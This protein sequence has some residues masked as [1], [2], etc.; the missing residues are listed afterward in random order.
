VTSGAA[1][2]RYAR[3]LFDVVLRENG[4]LE[5]VQR[6]F[7]QFVDL[8]AQHPVLATTLGNPAIPASKKK[9]V[10]QALVDR[11]GSISPVVAKLIMLLAERDRVMLLPDIARIFRE[12]LM[13]H[14]KVIR[15]EVTTAVA[16]PSEKLRALEQGLQQAT[17]RT[18]MLESKVDPA[19]IGGVITR[20]GSTV[21]D[22]S[23]TTQLQKMKQALIEAGQ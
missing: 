12:R 6:D 1:A 9:G 16:L 11:A 15:G 2:G 4:D 17:G 21:Y 23:V 20:L 10:A 14:Q 22:G 13:D 18:V 3:A 7:Q 19:I 8:F 5:Q